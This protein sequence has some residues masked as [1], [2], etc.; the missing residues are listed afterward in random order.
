MAAANLSHGPKPDVRR[1]SP[2]PTN[3][4][5]LGM[6]RTATERRRLA[7]HA[8]YVT[9][10]AR[11]RRARVNPNRAAEP[12]SRRAA[13]DLTTTEGIEPRQAIAA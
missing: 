5:K 3:P 4:C 2:N 12:V 13:R 7:R 9:G 6:K 10:A 8:E 11:V 1:R